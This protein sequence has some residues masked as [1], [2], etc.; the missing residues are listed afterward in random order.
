M[1]LA[2]EKAQAIHDTE[3][4]SSFLDGKDEGRIEG[5]Y[6]VAQN[7]LKRKRSIEEIMEDT[8]LSREEV[9]NLK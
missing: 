2:L 1:A 4:V 5:I 6:C 7:L 8:G 3:I 9:E